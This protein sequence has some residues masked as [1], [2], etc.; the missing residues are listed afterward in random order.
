[1]VKASRDGVPVVFWCPETP[2][3][4]LRTDALR[5]DA[6]NT[7][8]LK[9]KVEIPDDTLKKKLVGGKHQHGREGK[10]KGKSEK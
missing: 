8:S 7:Q 1:M 6:K 9:R 5:A 4:S 3:G 2:F 10:Y